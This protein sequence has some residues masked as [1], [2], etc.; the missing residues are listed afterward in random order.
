MESDLV[1]LIP[2]EGYSTMKTIA[3]TDYYS[4]ETDKAKNRIYLIIVGFWKN[5]SV[6]DYFDDITKAS[7]EVSRGF[8]ILTDVSGMETPPMEIGAL[9]EK[10]QNL[11]VKAGLKKTAE[12]LPKSHSVQKLSLKQWSGKSGMEKEIFNDRA[13]AEAW[14]DE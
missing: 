9:H 3:K 14:L 8:T 2:M 7:Q 4:I 5:I 1:R 11:L 10:A 13:L 12:I 6:P